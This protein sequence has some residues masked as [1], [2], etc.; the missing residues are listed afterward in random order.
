MCVDSKPR[1]S[2]PDPLISVSDHRFQAKGQKGQMPPPLTDSPSRRS[3]FLLSSND[4]IHRPDQNTHRR[5]RA[6]AVFTYLSRR[7]LSVLLPTPSN[8]S[9][10]IPTLF[11]MFM[12]AA[13][14]LCFVFSDL[15]DV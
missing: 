4:W 5:R 11:F 1:L 2:Q 12:S 15:C 7:V 8:D 9:T 3:E 13:A 6:A 14:R 10:V